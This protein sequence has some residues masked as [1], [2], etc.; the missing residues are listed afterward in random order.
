[1]R[2]KEEWKHAQDVC[3]YDTLCMQ[4][5]FHLYVIFDI[6]DTTMNENLFHLMKSMNHNDTF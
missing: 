6:N 5:D 4:C 1:M 3:V 2:T